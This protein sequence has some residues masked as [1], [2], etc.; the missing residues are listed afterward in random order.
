[1]GEQSEEYEGRV[2]S[3]QK[4]VAGVKIST[5]A[6]G[7]LQLA[8]VFLLAGSLVCIA[9]LLL[10][11]GLNVAVEGHGN[12]HHFLKRVFLARVRFAAKRVKR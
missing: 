1:V 4:R 12:L 5:R 6:D 9:L 8:H 3:D 7:H 10:L 2:Q 11:G